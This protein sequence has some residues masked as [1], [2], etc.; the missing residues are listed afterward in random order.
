MHPVM[1]RL[2][3]AI[4]YKFISNNTRNM[5]FPNKLR[6]KNMLFFGNK[7]RDIPETEPI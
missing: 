3:T 4:F 1:N 5:P 7:I 6:W 2:K